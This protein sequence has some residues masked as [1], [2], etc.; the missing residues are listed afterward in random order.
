MT[1]FASPWIAGLVALFAWWF[2]T[3]AILLLVR[4]ADRR[5]GFAHGQA[6]LAATPLLAL[7]IAL[8]LTAGADVAGAYAGFLGALAVW[9]W[10]ELTFLAGIVTGPA[11]RPC[12]PGLSTG[13]RFGHAWDALAHHETALALGLLAI[14]MAAPG[15]VAFWTYT[16][17]FGARISAKL[18]LFFGVPRINTEFMPARL[19]YLASHLR[20][21]PPGAFFAASVTLLT[22]AVGALGHGLWQATEPAARAGQALI[23]AIAALALL[24]HWLMVLPVPDARLWR[25]MLPAAP[26]TR[27]DTRDPHGL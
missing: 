27:D 14:T 4:R 26:T 23:V 12:P 10:I 22:L 7:G 8:I 17:L 15:G 1:A 16:V 20:I 24:E 13:A 9:G 5:G 25:W 11:A 2:S 21:G 3:G 18:N 6:V 19:G